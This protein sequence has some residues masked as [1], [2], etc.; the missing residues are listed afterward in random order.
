MDSSSAWLDFGGEWGS[1]STYDGVSPIDTGLCPSG[2][3]LQW[4]KHNPRVC[5]TPTDNHKCMHT[6]RPS[7][8]TSTDEYT[9][10]S[11]HTDPHS[12][13]LRGLTFEH[14]CGENEDYKE[15]LSAVCDTRSISLPSPVVGPLTQTQWEK[16]S[17]TTPLFTE[18]ICPTGWVARGIQVTHQCD[19][20]NACDR[21]WRLS[22]M[23]VNVAAG[24]EL[25][26]GST[27]GTGWMSKSAC[28]GKKTEILCSRAREEVVTAVWFQHARG[29]NLAYQEKVL[30]ACTPLR[31]PLS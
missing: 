11:C 25:D 3:H 31:A 20:N 15:K 6:D 4:D 28:S 27:T 5:P 21:W 18:L 22:C 30:V 7:A 1:S 24:Y 17:L 10:F 2:P 29:Q 12:Q 13:A 16:A 8:S 9:D 19:H 26:T 14:T 23:Q